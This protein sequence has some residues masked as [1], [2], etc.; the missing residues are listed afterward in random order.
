MLRTRDEL[1]PCRRN[2]TNEEIVPITIVIADGEDACR[3]T[4]QRILE[5]EKDIQIVKEV[6][7]GNEALQ[8]AMKFRPDILVL[9]SNLLGV[10]GS[11][12]LPSLIETVPKTNMILLTRRSSEQRILNALSYGARGYI[13]QTSLRHSL[14]SGSGCVC[15]RVMGAAK[16]PRQDS[17]ATR[18]AHEPTASHETKFSNIES[19]SIIYQEEWRQ[20]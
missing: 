16:D 13:A 2:V 4:C 8:A 15:R 17:G 18:D 10:N 12:F 19:Y 1:S 7:S 3:A 14:R 20:P 6:R 5:S 9:D 11:F